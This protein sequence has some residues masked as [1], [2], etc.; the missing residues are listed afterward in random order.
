M[1]QQMEDILKSTL[2]TGIAFGLVKLNM[3]QQYGLVR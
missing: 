1:L 2:V 3:E